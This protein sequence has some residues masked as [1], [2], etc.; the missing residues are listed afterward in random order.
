LGSN[1]LVKLEKSSKPIIA[2]VNG[3]AFG[4]G[5]ELALACDIRIASENASFALPELNL[6]ILPGAGGTQRLS[7]IIGL[8]RAKE[9]ILTGRS[10]TAEEALRYGLVS[11]V[12]PLDKLMESAQE[13]ARMIL[14]KG[15]L[16]VRLA[17]KCISASLS[18]DQDAGMFMELLS[19]G[20]LFSSEDR[21]EGVN[22]F[23]EKRRPKFQG[24]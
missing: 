23:L 4:G 20:V 2:A 8:G 1:V 13:T 3:F 10:I 14:A 16:A 5:C 12:A 15:P 6:G 21:M 18:T 19:I 24:K 11:K 17:K 22:A 7:K 9:I